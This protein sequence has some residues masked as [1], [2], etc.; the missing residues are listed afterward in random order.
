MRSRH[1]MRLSCAA[2]ACLLIAA[3]GSSAPA[4]VSTPTAAAAAI[5]APARVAARRLLDWPEFGLN[6]Q[7][8]DTSE[9]A[10]GITS[11]NVA[12]LRQMK[13][14]LAGTVDSSP[15]YLHG[16]SVGGIPHNVVVVSTTYGKTLAIDADNGKTLWTFTP[17]GYDRWAGS[18]QITVSSP[19]AGPD[20]LW[21]YA[22][23][24]NGLIH[25]LS[26]ANGSEDRSGAWPVSVTRDATHEKLGAALNID[27]PDLVVATSGYFGDAPPYQGHVVLID[28]TS[29]QIKAVFNTLCSDR[30]RLIVPSS[31]SASDS[32]ILSRSGVVVEPGG[33]RLLLDTGN[34]P[35]NGST[36][37][38][39]SVL[40]LTFPGL[41]LRQS[42]TP[43]DQAS[44]NSSDTDLGSSAPALLGQNRIV[45]A[46]KD[47]ILRVLEL[48]RLNGRSAFSHTLL[49]GE[50]QRLQIPE[51]GQLF[52][53]P[54]IWRRSGRTTMFVADENGTAAYVMRRG[55]LYQAWQNGT[56]GTS[57]VMAGGLLYVYDPSAGGIYVYRPGSPRPLAKLPGASG[58][59]NSPIVADGHIIEPGGNANDHSLNGTL[60]IFS[61]H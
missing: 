57:P 20:R 10:T 58:H 37:F 17:P 22:A 48:S 42:Y 2:S 31:C 16:V 39:D 15:V 55:R 24:P 3:C 8:T 33:G 44:L 13:L 34:G 14:S 27:G 47:G 32:A 51:G 40:E 9:D 18:A 30:H 60:E 54:A 56:P 38:G 59:W 53:A 19:L 1:F 7:R 52:T 29:G 49:G 43:A 45:L 6:P 12:H 36:N 50:I 26:L 4:G 61:A 25:K 41:K 35:W 11:A 21:V 5:P 23:S 46:G 28:R